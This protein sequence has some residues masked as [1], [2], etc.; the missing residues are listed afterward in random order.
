MRLLF[1]VLKRVA[2]ALPVLA[3]VVVVTFLLTRILPGD[4]AA[5]FAGQSDSF[6]AIE[7]TR[8]AMGLD[9]SLPVQFWRYVA[10]LTQGDLGRSFSTGRGVTAE[11]LERLPASLEL[12]T[13]AMLLGSALAIPLGVWAAVRQ[14]G[15]V[16]QAVR[17][18]T[19]A[20]VSLPAF[21]TG[22]MFI[23]IFY[24]ALEWAP[25]PIGRLDLF[26]SPPPHL[27]GFYLV[28]AALAG[29]GETWR[30]AAAQMLLPAISLGLVTL[31][32]I[33]RMTRGAMLAA[34][35]ADFVRTARAAGLS[36]MR[37][38]W[39]YAFP[40][41][42]LP[43]LTTLGMV[44]SYSLGGAV[45]VEKVFAWPGVGSFALDAL[46]QLDYA[47][48]QGFVLVLGVLYVALNLVVDIALLLADP[49]LRLEG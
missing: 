24:W 1:L 33:A 37:V 36:P 25:S 13:V 18:L 12:V 45:L 6:A 49:R 23:F 48:V 42:I 39:R 8:R 15:A 38:L 22:L 27:T 28:D 31:A 35:G 34:L 11:I 20:G 30:A 10:A 21:F 43:V 29:D 17:V 3:G 9:A 46:M 14:G 41:A 47:P 32:P 16:D 40:N 19:T 5:Y 7:E 26:S 2:A 4:P 44:F